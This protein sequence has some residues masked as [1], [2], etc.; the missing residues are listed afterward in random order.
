MTE[1]FKSSKMVVKDLI[2]LKPIKG[3]RTFL[4][5]FLSA[6]VGVLNFVNWNDFFNDWKSGVTTLLMATM[7]SF[8]RI[9]SDTP[10]GQSEHPAEVV[11]KK[12]EEIKKEVLSSNT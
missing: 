5:A 1:E 6:L 12:E 2:T 11:L 8:L 3:Y 10:A 4:F 7:F 9:I